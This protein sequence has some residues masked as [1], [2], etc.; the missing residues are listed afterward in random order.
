[1]AR[2]QRTKF[3]APVGLLKEARKELGYATQQE[4]LLA[5]VRQDLEHTRRNPPDPPPD[6]P[7]PW[8]DPLPIQYPDWFYLP[9]EWKET[10]V[11]APEGFLEDAGRELGYSD[12]EEMLLDL[13]R[14]ALLQDRQWKSVQRILAVPSDLA[15]L[16]DPEFRAQARR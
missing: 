4:M 5:L 16:A 12:T 2:M 15:R 13:V 3:F 9:G 6:Q 14:F 11:R 1:M 8:G 7:G 10:T